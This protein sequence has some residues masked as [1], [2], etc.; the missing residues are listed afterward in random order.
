MPSSRMASLGPSGVISFGAE[1]FVYR[2]RA[3]GESVIEHKGQVAARSTRTLPRGTS[4][5][6]AFIHVDGQARLVLDGDEVC[7]VAYE[8]DLS[9]PIQ[10]LRAILKVGVQGGDLAVSNLKIHRDIYYFA[11]RDGRFGLNGA[12][13]IGPDQYVMLG[14]NSASS[15]DSRLWS[16]IRYELK[17]GTVVIGDADTN[18]AQPESERFSRDETRGEIQLTDINGRRVVLQR[19]EVKDF[20]AQLE[21]APFVPRENLIGQAFMVFWPMKQLKLIR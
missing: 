14:D 12:L 21:F 13:Q 11:D 7:A 6:I 5:R 2:L 1:T 16:R 18:G 20:Y 4:A 9:Q 8:P 3:E 15:K 17:D 19:D 10:T